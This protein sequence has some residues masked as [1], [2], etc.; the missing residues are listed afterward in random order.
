MNVL[1][2]VE[3]KTTIAQYPI[4]KESTWFGVDAWR[5]HM[6]ELRDG[7]DDQHSRQ[8]WWWV[9]W[10][11]R[12]R[13]PLLR[14]RN[15]ISRLHS[16]KAYHPPLLFSVNVRPVYIFIST[17]SRSPS[18]QSQTQNSPLFSFQICVL[19]PHYPASLIVNF[20]VLRNRNLRG[21]SAKSVHLLPRV[22]A[23]RPFSTI[24]NK[25]AEED[26]QLILIPSHHSQPGFWPVLQDV[27]QVSTYSPLSLYSTSDSQTLEDYRVC[28]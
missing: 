1:F 27:Y 22:C 19:S 23:V 5:S 9:T 21:T 15:L 13:S 17:P 16:S 10:R 24:R 14:R 6:P 11:A 18:H 20:S 12:W 4:H 7:N 3:A 8:T 28:P 25:S 26:L 2:C